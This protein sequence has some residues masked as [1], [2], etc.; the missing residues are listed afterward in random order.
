MKKAFGF[1]LA[2][3]S[4]LLT[5]GAQAQG[6]H[7]QANVPFDFTVGDKLYPAGS[8]DIQGTVNGN[9]SVILRAEGGSGAGISVS[10]TCSSMKPA[11]KTVLVFESMG[12]EYYLAQ[13]WTAGNDRGTE[14]PKPKAETR[15]ARGGKTEEV[16]VAANLVK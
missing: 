14:L 11:A 7:V 1:L 10:H 12:G 6:L 13:I 3:A 9:Q 2:A 16:I 8:Y 4:L 5:S 15:L